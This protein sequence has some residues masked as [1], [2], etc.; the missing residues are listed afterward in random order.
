L[1]NPSLAVTDTV[2][3][4][5]LPF[6][7]PG[8]QYVDWIGMDCYDRAK[9]STFNSC[10]Q[11]FYKT[12]SNPATYGKPMMIT[13]TGAVQVPSGG[14][15]GQAAYLESSLA[16]LPKYPQIKAFSYF[17]GKGTSDWT[18]A[19]AGLQAFQAIGANSYFAPMP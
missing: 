7:Y 8:N 19:T 15:T 10:F 2:P 3:V 12:Y 11:S 6:Y 18:L 13:E 5:Q 16:T 17:D 4:T 14:A 9:T 1:W